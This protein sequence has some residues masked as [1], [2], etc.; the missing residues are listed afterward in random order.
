M[1]RAVKCAF[2]RSEIP[3][4][5]RA[6]S[7][8]ARRK[9]STGKQD[10]SARMSAGKWF[11]RLVGLQKKLRAPDGCPW[12]KEQTHQSLRPF[13]IEETYEA[14]DAMNGRDSRKFAEELGDLLL[15]IVFHA[16]MA[17]EEGKFDIADVIRA[18]HDK[19]VRRHPHVFGKARA[20]DSAEVLKNWEEIKAEE[21]GKGQKSGK[22]EFQSILS[23]VPQGLPALVEGFQLARRAANIGFDWD[24]A[25]E[26]LEKIIEETGEVRRALATS[27]AG[28]RGRGVQV[29]VEEEI[30][31][32]FFS[33]MNLARLVGVEPEVA[34]KRANG[35]FSNRFQWMER[36]ALNR[37]SRLADFSRA[38]M[39]KLWNESKAQA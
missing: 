30:G 20:Q 16:E 33:V 31:D 38:E 4:L 3:V 2:A 8:K 17:S 13:L 39:E 7:Q 22:S 14:L 24:N 19:M 25:E 28:A 5:K 27:R 10:R 18:V 36:Q 6:R 35:K 23:G 32:L 34:M 11:E 37:G 29:E 9:A 26:V 15:Q 1:P 21:R 12:D